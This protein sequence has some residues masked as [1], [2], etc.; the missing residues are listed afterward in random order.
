VLTA[1]S[2]TQAF[3]GG[4][5]H[6]QLFYSIRHLV[7]FFIV[8]S[9]GACISKAKPLISFNGLYFYVRP[10]NVKWNVVG[11]N[12]YGISCG[13]CYVIQKMILLVGFDR[14]KCPS[15]KHHLNNVTWRDVVWR[16]G[17]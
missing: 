4:W 1:I 12:M 13:V 6:V 15:M 11:W 16:N 14:A 2:P 7:N 8:S 5:R 3:L 10:K 9:F 17:L